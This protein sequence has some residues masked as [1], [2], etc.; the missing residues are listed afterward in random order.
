MASQTQ[1]EGERERD[2]WMDGWMNGWTDDRQLDGWGGQVDYGR[3]MFKF[4]SLFATKFCN[5][6]DFVNIEMWV[7]L[8]NSWM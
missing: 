4:N 5:P 6:M 2:G 8:S 3:R 7:L 1:R